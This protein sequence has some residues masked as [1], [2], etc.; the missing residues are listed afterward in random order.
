[1]YVIKTATVW[2]PNVLPIMG[3]PLH[4][5]RWVSGGSLALASR[6]F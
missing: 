6:L 3:L 2:V 1:M 4:A 5:T